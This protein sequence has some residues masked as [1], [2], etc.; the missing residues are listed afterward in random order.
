M[1]KLNIQEALQNRESRQQFLYLGDADFIHSAEGASFVSQKINRL[2]KGFQEKFWGTLG[3]FDNTRIHW[4]GELLHSNEGQFESEGITRE[5]KEDL[6]KALGTTELN[7]HQ[8]RERF[9]SFDGVD[10]PDDLRENKALRLTLFLNPNEGALVYYQLFDADEADPDKGSH[11]GFDYDFIQPEATKNDAGLIDFNVDKRD[12]LSY[13]IELL[14][15][16][17]PVE[18]GSAER[19]RNRF[20]VKVLTFLREA[21]TA[22]SII[23]RSEARLFKS[24]ERYRLLVFHRDSDAFAAPDPVSNPLFADRKTLFLIHG[25]FVDTEASYEALLSR[26][27]GKASLLKQYL[28]SEDTPHTQAIAFDHPTLFDDAAENSQRLMKALEAYER[29]FVFRKKVD[30]IG[31]SRGALVAKYLAMAFEQNNGSNPRVPIDKIVTVSGANGCGYLSKGKFF[32]NTLLKMLKK[33]SPA[34][35]ALVNMAQLSVKYLSTRAGLDLMTP[36]S[37]RLNSILNYQPPANSLISVLPIS[38]D[39]EVEQAASLGKKLAAFFLRL[40]DKAVQQLLGREHDFVIGT[41]EQQMPQPFA[42]ARVKG[43]KVFNAVHGRVL[44]LDEVWP[45]MAK[46]LKQ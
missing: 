20:V 32:I 7:T 11:K 22:E 37:M 36:D 1:A 13:Q 16:F 31:T 34:Q 3:N 28:E 45:F 9:I 5:L 44:D 10:F 17:L 15:K 12:R 8:I 35:L 23:E 40:G 26:S 14:P 42:L 30:V 24:E 41:R 18:A 38:A 21:A 27:N 25:T 46:F 33:G 39:F 43:N 4:S 19:V 29:G 6:I 2:H